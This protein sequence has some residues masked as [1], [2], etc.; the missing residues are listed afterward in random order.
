MTIKEYEE[1]ILD[2]NKHSFLKKWSEIVPCFT[3]LIPSPY[4]LS[5]ECGPI[6]GFLAHEMV[7]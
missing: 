7:C 1:Y 3:K 4:T 2:G 5:K 6:I